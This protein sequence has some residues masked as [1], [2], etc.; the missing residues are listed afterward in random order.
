[1]IKLKELCPMTD[2]NYLSIK[3]MRDWDAPIFRSFQY[4]DI[5]D[6]Q[7]NSAL[8]D[9]DNL[10]QVNPKIDWQDDMFL[11]KH[12]NIDNEMTHA[13][14]IAALVMELKDNPVFDW[15]IEFDTFSIEQCGFCIPNGHHRIRAAE[16]LGID[17]VPF[18]LN[19]HLDLIDELIALADINQATTFSMV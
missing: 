13:Y 4:D 15:P 14:R 10:G 11:F 6:E 3:R 9:L 8:V 12:E 7:I 17:V 18:S 16:F 1:M 19:G 5:T 2:I